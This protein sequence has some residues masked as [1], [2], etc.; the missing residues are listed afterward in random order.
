MLRIND[1]KI[2]DL[3]VLFELQVP[4]TKNKTPLKR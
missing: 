2:Q 4:C 1:K 3:P